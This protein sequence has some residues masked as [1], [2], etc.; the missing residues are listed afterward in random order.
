MTSL[1]KWNIYKYT[2]IFIY[3]FSY[4]KIHIYM[5]TYI[6]EFSYIKIQCLFYKWENI[7]FKQ[8]VQYHIQRQKQCWQWKVVLQSGNVCLS[9]GNLTK[10]QMLEVLTGLC[11]NIHSFCSTISNRLAFN[12]MKLQD[13][14]GKAHSFLIS[15]LQQVQLL[16]HYFRICCLL[17][18]EDWGEFTS[19]PRIFL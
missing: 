5:N 8:F 11:Q 17:F 19:L 12:I 6:Y 15:P 16:K 13:D 2:N 3:E 4:I 7:G 1:E 10:P 18:W 9:N 14:S